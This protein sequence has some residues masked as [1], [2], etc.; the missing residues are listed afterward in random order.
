MDDDWNDD[1]SAPQ[2]PSEDAFSSAVDRGTGYGRGRGLKIPAD[3]DDH[4]PG[5]SSFGGGENNGYG[6]HGNDNFGRSSFGSRGS[7]G[8]F[9]GGDRGGGDR[10]GRGRRGGG[11]GFRGGRG[12][13]SDDDN[14]D[15][16]NGDNG[17]GGGGGDGYRGRGGRGGG[18]GR[19]DRGD[20]EDGRPGSGDGGD[21]KPREHYIPP[22]PSDMPEEIFGSGISS[23]INFSKYDDIQIKVSGNQPP[24]SI[25]SFRGSGLRPIL[26]E[27]IER[28]H[29]SKP[30]PVQKNAIPIIMGGRDLMACAQT[31]S[32][33]TAAFLLPIIH[34]ILENPTGDDGDDGG[35]NSSVKPLAVIVSP[36][37]ELAIQIFNESR[38]FAH[39]SVIR[40]CV[41]YG[42]TSTV[43]QMGQVRKGCHV[44]VAT[45]GRLQDMVDKGVI[46][47][48]SVRFFVL[49]EADRM[50]DMGFMPAVEKLL[51][52]ST[53]VETGRRQTL[54]FSATFPEE[55][56][57]LAGKFLHDYIFLAVGIVGGACSDVEQRIYE[58]TKFEKRKK[59]VSLLQESADLERTLVF[60]E[61]KRLADFIAA[62]L[63]EQQFPT[64]SIHGDRLQS[65]REGALAD[66]K[67]GTM[68]I[69]VA[70]AVAAR[71]LDIKDVAHVVNFD[72]PK[73]IDEYVH[74]IGRTGRVGNRGKATS[75]YDPDQDGALAKDLVKILK[76]A[77]QD[78]PPF[79]ESAAS[80]GGFSS[81]YSGG[82]RY[83]GRDVRRF[84]DQ[85][86]SDFQ[87][88]A[89]DG[90]S[91]E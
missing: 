46:A 41:V 63:S 59:L 4:S 84:D 82:G 34:N 32:G 14:D 7:R 28:C 21:E 70:T 44:L 19:G 12:R 72:L 15:R 55:I 78:I 66:F 5:F 6:D 22:E 1:Y 10:G 54:M 16:Q 90:E 80:A 33:K 13:D 47:F 86:S 74:R 8:G 71:G 49:D 42:G 69:L 9:R 40:S 38:K 30:T 35:Y 39:S 79:L 76:Q 77:N 73:S 68:P 64:T 56:Q 53:M 36:T 51:E 62:F 85:G 23:G 48:N 81:G 89:E 27:N 18:R 88:A 31:G 2:Q 45:P 50:L 25:E 83:G 75:F 37:R 11:G 29:Y 3:N 87:P 24:R 43:H 20:R 58:V 67:R 60:V 65:Q 26:V 17:Y 91:W 57:K 61:Q 52:H